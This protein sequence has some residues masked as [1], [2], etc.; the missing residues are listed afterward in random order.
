MI[1]IGDTFKPFLWKAD[2]DMDFS[3]ECLYCDTEV[4]GLKGYR[5]EDEKGSLLRVAVCPNCQKVNAKY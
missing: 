3:S 1:S 2:F 5:V 4:M